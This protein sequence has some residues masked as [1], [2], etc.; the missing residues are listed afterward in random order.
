MFYCSNDRRDSLK[1][2]DGLTQQLQ[3]FCALVEKMK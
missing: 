2:M 3:S 1:V